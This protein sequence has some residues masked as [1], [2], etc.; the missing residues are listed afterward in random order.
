MT[1]T[2]DEREAP[3]SN[4]RVRVRQFDA[5]RHDQS[6]DLDDALTSKPTERQLLW[7]DITDEIDPD[8]ARRMAEAFELDRST[9]QALEVPGDIPHLGVHGSY[10]HVRVAVE[11]NDQ[12][13]EQTPWLDIVSGGNVV[14]TSHRK[15]IKFLDDMDD[16]IQADTSFGLLDASTFMASVL[17]AA[18]TSYFAAVDAIEDE[19]DLLDAKSLR[20]D[21]RHHLLDDLV[22]V[23]RRIARLRRVLT[24]HRQ[25][26]AS[27]GGAEL[28]QVTDNPDSVAAFR[29]VS[30][31]FEAAIGAVEDSREVLIGSFEVYM[32]RTAQ[33]TNDVMKVLALATVLLLPGSLVAGL[34]GM[35]MIIPLPEDD[36]RMWWMVVGAVVA[37]AGAILLIARRRRW[38]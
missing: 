11:P 13:L 36:P 24:D 29:A 10:L 8:R 9:L 23:R 22:V 21:G 25:L 3:P 16:R 28:T 15:P 17:S 2:R 20:D 31:R 34:L 1:A 6:L 7:I 37:F 35:N 38:L 32:T 12:D 4:G 18:V 26:F 33:R 19:V 30:E 5:D 14:I 27:L